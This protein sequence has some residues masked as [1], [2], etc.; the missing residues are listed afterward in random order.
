MTT[1]DWSDGRITVKAGADSRDLQAAF[2]SAPEGGIIHLE[3]G[4]YA[5]DAPLHIETDGLELRGAGSDRTR[6]E[7]DM[8]GHTDADVLT[9]AGSWAI[10]DTTLARSVE[11]GARTLVLDDDMDL[12]AGDYLW[13]EAENTDAFFD[14]IGDTVWRKDKPL[15]TSMVEVA[16]VDGDT[17]ELANATHFAFDSEITRVEKMRPV[18]GVEISGLS[19]TYTLGTPDPGLFEN[20]R[21][22]YARTVALRVERS[23]DT[24]M[25]DI[26][27]NASGSHAFEW[28]RSLD[29]D[30]RDLAAHGS[31][32]KGGGGNGY[33]FH[34]KNV[35]DSE[36][37][38]LEDSGMRHSA[39]FASYYSA[40]GN[41]VE[42]E[43]TT[44]DI[45]L[46]GGRDHGNVV[47]VGQSI[48]PENA[49]GMS[50][51][52]SLN[53]AGAPYGAPTDPA[54]N[55]V[56]F[57]RVVGSKRADLVLGTDGDDVL[58]PRGGHDV[59]KGRGGDDLLYA[60][61][62]DSWGDD[63]LEGGAGFD[64]AVFPGA[65]GD[66]TVRV[67]DGGAELHVGEH[68]LHG[69][70]RAV[71]GGGD[72]ARVEL[73]RAFNGYRPD[74]ASGGGDD[75]RRGASDTGRDARRDGDPGE[76]EAA[77]GGDTYTGSATADVF[78]WDHWRESRPGAADTVAG[79]DARKDLID[80]SGLD[81]DVDAA[82][83]QGFSWIGDAAFSGTVRE[84]R[85]ADGILA[86]DNDGDGAAEFVIAL[87]GHDTF[88]PQLLPIDGLRSVDIEGS[89]GRDFY[90]I[91]DRSHDIVEQAGGGWDKVESWHSRTLETHVEQLQLMGEAETAA[92][93]DARNVLIG[94]DGRNT[95]RGERGD[96]SLY[97]RS[98][99]D[100]LYGGSG[101][102][103]L[104]GGGGR[105][106]LMGGGGA[107][108]LAGGGGADAYR[109]TGWDLDETDRIVEFSHHEGDIIDVARIDADTRS[110]GDQAFSFIGGDAFSGTAGELRF[111]DRTLAGDVDGDGRADLL[112]AIPATS[113]LHADDFVL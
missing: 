1:F 33:A 21:D 90:R 82:G 113:T 95:L 78:A 112:V 19:M 102:D 46:H 45:N 30:A 69:V 106:I 87:P 43:E 89:S 31:H 61:T 23:V 110:E 52:L 28:G 20:A 32:N 65:R 10:H 36:L 25:S 18:E 17:V 107:D 67:R 39:V 14:E 60:G 42:V 76:R 24:E 11:Q 98:G 109:F 71:F 5:I 63:R 92:G 91:A 27:I 72:G 64:T 101:D 53:D 6:F 85:M 15:R 103:A 86:G 66:Y 108:T 51:V 81:A 84:M 99:D 59:V 12:G 94:H 2:D 29:L 68:V 16:E 13:L 55:D 74:G 44:R 111:D 37:T 38:G 75:G 54:A 40:V 83:M 57:N 58:D 97:G 96:D 77:S 41:E 47:Y 50:P 70:E 104:D 88:D 8:T 48:R 3:A 100:R 105:D 35:Y 22:D 93:N 79:F 80:L 4:T 73:A 56:S 7:V 34:I 49:D 9:V 62:G 26:T